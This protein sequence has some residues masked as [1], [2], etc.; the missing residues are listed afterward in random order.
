MVGCVKNEDVI[1]RVEK[2]NQIK[3]E[4]AGKRAEKNKHVINNILV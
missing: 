4:D 3:K 2:E 1:K